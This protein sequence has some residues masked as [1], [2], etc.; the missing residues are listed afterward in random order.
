MNWFRALLLPLAL[1]FAAIA[2]FEFGARFGAAN[3]RAV[4]LAAQLENYLNYYEQIR[5]RADAA[6]EVAIEKIVDNHIATAALQR[7]V[8]FLRFRREP[9]ASLE[10]ALGEA[11]ALRGEA[12]LEHMSSEPE[13][14]GKVQ[15]PAAKLEEIRQ[16]VAR[17][18]REME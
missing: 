18:R 14:P 2:I 8:W 1:V 9:R 15:V 12:A 3:V 13:A 16:A 17:A 6:S 7:D 10:R 4:A 11:L 5:G